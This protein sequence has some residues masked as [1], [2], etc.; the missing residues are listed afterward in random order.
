MTILLSLQTH[1]DSESVLPHYTA[2]YYIRILFCYL[3]AVS[4][5]M[6]FQQS[7]DKHLQKE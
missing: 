3:K 6:F 4:T 7:H 2:I 1:F 5:L